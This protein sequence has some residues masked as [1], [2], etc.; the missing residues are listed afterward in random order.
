MALALLL[1]DAAYY[2]PFGGGTPGPRFLIPLLPCLALPLAIA[3]A[4]WRV[5]TLATAA[6]SAFWMAAATVAG[7]LLPEDKSVTGWITDI[8]DEHELVN[9][10]LG[11]GRV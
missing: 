8:V 7:P 11:N 6:V 5:V 10:V 1:Y 4:R 2:L 9:S 3:Y